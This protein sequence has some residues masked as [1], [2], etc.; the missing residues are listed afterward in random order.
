MSGVFL[1]LGNKYFALEVGG[2][3]KQSLHEN[4]IY[5]N[6]S[7]VD[8]SSLSLIK[9]SCVLSYL[10]DGSKTFATVCGN[11]FPLSVAY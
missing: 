1:F 4:L 5:R 6:C 9:E 10:K 2:A 3:E 11:T 7:I 8:L